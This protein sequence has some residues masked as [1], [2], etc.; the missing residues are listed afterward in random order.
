MVDLEEIAVSA[1]E[2]VLDLVGAGASLSNPQFVVWALCKAQEATMNGGFE[3]FFGNDWPDQP[4]YSLFVQAFREAGAEAGAHCIER[5]VAEFPFDAPHLDYKK[6]R[7]HIA[8]SRRL[9]S[10]DSV[11]DRLGGELI[12]LCDEN[13]R[14]LGNYVLANRSSF[15]G[16]CLPD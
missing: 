9:V 15:P 14:A 13:Y 7:E 2:H 12:E 6:R 10:G 16:L 3:F 1:Y 4:P 5:A 11:I 8:D